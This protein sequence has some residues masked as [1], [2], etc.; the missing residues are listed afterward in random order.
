MTKTS[1]QMLLVFI[2]FV[3]VGIAAATPFVVNNVM[4]TGGEYRFANH[5]VPTDSDYSIKTTGQTARN[6]FLSGK[7]DKISSVDIYREGL[8][9]KPEDTLRVGKIKKFLE[10]YTSEK[11]PEKMAILLVSNSKHPELMTAIGYV[12]TQFKEGSKGSSGELGK[13]QLM[14]FWRPKGYNQFNDNQ[15]LKIAEKIIESNL[16]ETNGN[17]H[18]SV[19]RYNGSGP[20][21]RIY[22]KKVKEALKL[23]EQV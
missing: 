7:N 13:W 10:L 5:E 12:E 11:N 14:S 2:S 19:M 1:Q 3:C 16:S 20:K 17:I 4:I 23:I 22:L 6:E 21:T 8:G 9:I 18:K 15:N